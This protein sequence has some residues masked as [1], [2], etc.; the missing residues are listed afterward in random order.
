MS[1]GRRVLVIGKG[2]REHALAERLLVSA[3]VSEVVVAPGNAGT[4]AAPAALA[5]KILRNA[6]GS[7]L[8]LAKS[9]RPDLVLVGPE[10][11]LC[12][13]IV[14]ELAAAGL[15]VYGPSRAASRLEGSK[16]FLKD[17]AVANGVH[18]A[19][20]VTVRSEAELLR[21][22]QEFATPPVVKADG[23]C[24][25]KGVVVAET[26]EEALASAREMLS[27]RAFGAAGHTVVL[28]ERLYGTEVSAHA[29][30]D[31][32]RAVLLPFVQD[33]KRLQ[34][35]DRGPNTG[36][37]GTYGPVTMPEPRLAD[38]IQRSIVD[39][40]LVG[41][42]RAGTPFRGTMF[43]GLMLQPDRDPAL[44]EI[45]VRFGDPETQILMN[46]LDGDFCELLMAAARGQLQ[47]DPSLSTASTRHALCV[48]MAAPGYPAEPRLGGEIRGL[49]AAGAL[50][51]VRV[52]HAGT[53]VGPR[54]PLTAGGRVLAVTGIGATLPEAH[55]RAYD[56]VSMI[57][58]E[59]KQLR[60]DIAHT[61][62]SQAVASSG[63][64]SSG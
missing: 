25:G 51:G 41:M 48:V 33:H 44:I 5:G 39:K 38:Y 35:G 56:A 3:S 21:G 15:L 20:Y 45:N 23:L 12:E 18:T 13:G 7:P 24:A 28:E 57:D 63:A 1:R 27:G 64:G 34:D 36:G 58:F 50:E 43:A 4:V 16:A 6:E 60:R 31:G 54:G 32:T 17:F 52:Y 10:A 8:E 11:P 47:P 22:L 53:R 61:A 26:H 37:M 14:D 46:V 59:G 30:C 40:L 9:W 62:P 49:E 2:G 42:A 29:I 55:R 19:R